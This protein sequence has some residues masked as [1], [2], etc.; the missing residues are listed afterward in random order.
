[1]RKI[2]IFAILLLCS[3]SIAY[4]QESETYLKLK[5]RHRYVEGYIIKLDS[6][7]VLGLIKDKIQDEATRYE[8]VDFF[9]V[10]GSK[11]RYRP[12]DLKG[13]GY[14]AE[15]F[16][17]DYGSFYKI[18]SSGVKAGLYSKLISFG[19]G[20]GSMSASHG[21]EQRNIYVNKNGKKDFRYVTRKGFKEEFSQYFGDCEKLKLKILSEQV[22]SKDIELVLREYNDCQ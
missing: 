17:S 22:T 16:V 13:Y 2:K 11:T 10:D 18:V 9:A 5:S 21:Y 6:V 7:K 19:G 15:N 3:L 1:M 20:G 12:Y 14:A 4:A 8:W